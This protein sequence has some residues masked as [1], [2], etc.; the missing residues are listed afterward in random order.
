MAWLAFN[1]F[2]D[3]KLDAMSETGLD[4]AM[5]LEIASVKGR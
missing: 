4:T 1:D 3:T 2:N 5:S